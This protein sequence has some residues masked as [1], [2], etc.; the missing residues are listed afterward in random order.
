MEQH[1]QRGKHIY[2]AQAGADTIMPSVA[3]NGGFGR[4]DQRPI[5]HTG[6]QT[7]T[8][9]G[10]YWHQDRQIHRPFAKNGRGV[11]IAVDQHR[12]LFDPAVYWCD[13]FTRME[14]SNLGRFNATGPRTA[15]EGLSRRTGLPAACEAKRGGCSRLLGR[16]KDGLHAKL[17]TVAD[18]KGRPIS[19][20]FSAGQTSDCIG[21]LALPSSL[22]TV[23]T[24]LADGGYDADRFRN[25]MIERHIQPCIPSRGCRKMAIP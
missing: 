2:R 19:M 5:D 20:C 15:G 11:G 9:A 8:Q 13:P 21:A 6:N 10:R 24:L 3:M 17:R 23:K 1:H 18:G 7:N 4:G 12:L 25:A 16:I 22:P 14:E